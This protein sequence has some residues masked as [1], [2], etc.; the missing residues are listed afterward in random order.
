[1]ASKKASG[2]SA[3]MSAIANE[4]QWRK[5]LTLS[6]GEI[7]SRPA[8]PLIDDRFGRQPGRADAEGVAFADNFF[9][10]IGS[11]DDPATTMTRPIRARKP[12]AL[13][14]GLAAAAS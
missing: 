5:S 12:P 10:V 7:H 1:M 3:Y 11:Q 6:D 4:Q 2:I 9:Y 14:P 13:P 8:D